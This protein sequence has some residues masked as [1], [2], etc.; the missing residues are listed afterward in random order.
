MNVHIIKIR[1]S[2]S[3]GQEEAACIWPTQPLQWVIYTDDSSK[4]KNTATKLP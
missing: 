2:E 3:W 4:F 1:G